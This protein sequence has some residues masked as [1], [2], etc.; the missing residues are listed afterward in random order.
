MLISKDIHE[1][2]LKLQSQILNIMRNTQNESKAIIKTGG[3]P[4]LGDLGAK[5]EL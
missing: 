5:Q 3:P 2:R 1:K 4:A